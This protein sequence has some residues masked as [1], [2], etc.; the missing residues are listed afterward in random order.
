MTVKTICKYA[1]PNNKGLYF[2]KEGHGDLFC[3]CNQDTCQY[4]NGTLRTISKNKRSKI[5]PSIE[6]GDDEILVAF[7]NMIKNVSSYRIAKLANISDNAALQWKNYGIVPRI[8]TANKVLK[9][10]GYELRIVK[11]ND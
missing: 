10:L 2:C 8:D 5:E 7:Y 3:Q 1:E 6:K 9:A 11:L 4:Y